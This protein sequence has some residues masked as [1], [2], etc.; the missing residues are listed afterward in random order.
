[1]F[2][3]RRRERLL[4]L[5]RRQSLERATP[6]SS[7]ARAVTGP[8]AQTTA[9]VNAPV[10]SIVSWLSRIKERTHTVRAGENDPIVFS[11]SC[12]IDGIELRPAIWRKDLN[13]WTVDYGC[14]GS[15]K[16]AGHVF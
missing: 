4:L 7:S 10:A 5:S 2:D 11:L 13:G 1:M 9:P 14:S 16:Q 8:I 15:F 12:W 6:A 3:D